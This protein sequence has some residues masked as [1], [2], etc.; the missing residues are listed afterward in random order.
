MAFSEYMN[1]TKK[2]S[3]EDSIEQIIIIQQKSRKD[4]ISMLQKCMFQICKLLIYGSK[5]WSFFE[6]SD[7]DL[8]E[9]ANTYSDKKKHLNSPK[10]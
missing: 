6:M 3:A 10:K 7:S 9:V 5:S 8:S 4:K 2:E 1:F